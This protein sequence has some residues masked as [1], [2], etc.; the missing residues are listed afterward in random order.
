MCV[1]KEGIN[2]LHRKIISTINHEETWGLYINNARWMARDVVFNLGEF[3]H[4]CVLFCWFS[5]AAFERSQKDI[6]TDV[7]PELIPHETFLLCCNFL[8]FFFF[9][10]EIYLHGTMKYNLQFSFGKKVGMPEET[11]TKL[12]SYQLCRFVF[13][14]KNFPWLDLWNFI[15]EI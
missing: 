7:T 15:L 12:S 11:R 8:N 5:W 10:L 4:S 14:E 6:R 9:L 3:T 1:E 2:Y 13:F